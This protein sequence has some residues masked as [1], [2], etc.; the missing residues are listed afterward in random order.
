MK[1]EEGYESAEVLVVTEK[2]P[3][4]NGFWTVCALVI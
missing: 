1:A 2:T 4:L 3:R